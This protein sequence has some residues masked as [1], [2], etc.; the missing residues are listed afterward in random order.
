MSGVNKVILVGNLGRKPEI[1]YTS[2]GI[3]VA[4]FTLATSERWGRDESG[5]NKEHTEWHNLVAWRKLAEICG[6]YLDK[7]S[8]IYCE[9]RL[10]TSS[11]TTQEGEKRYKT[12]IHIDE[13]VMLSARGERSEV[14]AGTYDQ[15]YGQYGGGNDRGGGA[16]RKEG[17]AAPTSFPGGRTATEVE[18]PEVI[19][20][21]N[22]DD[23]Q[24]F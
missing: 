9:G 5:Q 11:Y 3:P 19:N 13:M 16:F 21:D 7:G 22:L 24:F 18:P 23:D 12:E 15:E 2:A 6:Q 10:R 14:P 4:N 1:R 8:K 17:G 20:L